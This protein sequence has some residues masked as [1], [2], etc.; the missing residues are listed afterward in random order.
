MDRHGGRVPMANEQAA[1]MTSHRQSEMSALLRARRTGQPWVISD[2]G[3]LMTAVYSIQYYDDASLLPTA[4]E[5]TARS[6]W[7]LFCQGDFP[8]QPDPKRDGMHAR[9]M[10][11]EILAAVFAE[12]PELPVLVVQGCL[13]ERIEAVL[14]GIGRAAQVNQNPPD[15]SAR[16]TDTRRLT[17]EF[18]TEPPE[19]GIRRD[20]SGSG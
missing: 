11:Q 4:V 20:G 13:D 2:S 9:A 6:D 10:S 5:W 7:V 17:P 14:S 19:P 3:P 1:L 8:W 18:P 12:H 16:F 15:R